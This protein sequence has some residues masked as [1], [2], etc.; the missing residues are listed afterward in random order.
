MI[1]NV[2]G[3]FIGAVIVLGGI[4]WILQHVFKEDMDSW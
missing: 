4:G 1:L 3:A 2:I